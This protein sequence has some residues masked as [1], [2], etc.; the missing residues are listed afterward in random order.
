M[1]TEDTSN[2]RQLREFRGVNIERSFALSSKLDNGVFRIDV[3]LYLE[4]DHPFYER[5]RPAEKAC[6]RAA[7]LEFP[8]CT[9]V[10]VV[11]SESGVESPMDGQSISPGKIHDLHRYGDG[12]YEMGGEFGVISIHSD[13]PLLKIKDI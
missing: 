10:S 7:F 5:P 6:Y 13:R 2:W 11:N 3:D 4:K 9:G 8:E 12:K 1:T